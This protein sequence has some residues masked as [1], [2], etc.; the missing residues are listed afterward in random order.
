MYIRASEQLIRTFKI[1]IGPD[2]NLRV[3]DRIRRSR[4][5]EAIKKLQFV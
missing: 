4:N 1:I 5:Q 2:N 3:R